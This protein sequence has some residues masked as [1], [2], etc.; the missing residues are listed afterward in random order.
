L[1][2]SQAKTLQPREHLNLPTEGT[3]LQLPM[4]RT[5]P[6]TTQNDGIT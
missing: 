1:E 2:F 4:V 5:D 6:T 3:E